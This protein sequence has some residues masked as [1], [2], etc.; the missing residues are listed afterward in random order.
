MGF[1][2]VAALVYLDMLVLTLRTYNT[3]G[4]SKEV[5]S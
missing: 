1:Y 2:F 3:G 4:S 5:F